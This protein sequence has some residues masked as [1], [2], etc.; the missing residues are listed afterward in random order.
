MNLIKSSVTNITPQRYLEE[1]I[2][3]HIELCGRTCYTEDTEVLT[4]TGFKL[5]KDLTDTDLVLTYNPE[6]NELVYDN[7][8]LIIKDYSGDIIESTHLNLKFAVTP[9]HRLYQSTQT[10]RDYKF[11]T[12]EEAYS[13]IKGSKQNKFRIPKFFAGAY[14]HND[15]YISELNNTIYIKNGSRPDTPQTINLPINNDFIDL[16]GAF[17][18]E[19][20]TFHG[21][22]YGTGSYCQI[23]Q[24]INSKLYT[25]VINALSNLKIKYSISQ[26]PR[27]PDI[28]WIKFGNKVYVET[29]ECL[30]GRYSKNIHLPVWFR[31]L[32]KQQMERLLYVL[33][34]GDGSHNKTRNE[35]YLS[36][37]KT[38]LNQ[39]Q[40]LHILTGTNATV[41]YDD[42][43]SQKCYTEEN[44]RDSWVISRDQLVKKHYSGKVYCTQTSS[45]I[46]CIRY[47][48][49]TCWCGNCYKS[50]DKITDTSA[51][52]FVNMLKKN[53]HRSVLEHG[54]VYLKLSLDL[55][56]PP[57][58]II[59]LSDII[60]K[61]RVNP[62]SEEYFDEIND[63]YYITTN[64]RVIIEN[65]WEE[66]LQY[67]I[68][69]PNEHQ[70]KRYT[71]RITCSRAIANEVVRHRQLSFSQEST[72][73]CNYSTEKFGK[74]LTYIIPSKFNDIIPIGF[75]YKNGNYRLGL[76]DP[77]T[78][79][80]DIK[81][82]IPQSLNVPAKECYI[83]E[84]YLD[85]LLYAEKDYLEL[86]ELGLKPEEARGVLPLDLKTDL[87]VTGTKS[88]WDDFFEL[89]CAK[90]AHPDIQVIANEIKKQIG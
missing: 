53:K 2:L 75:A 58:H 78:L 39:V 50:E 36:I 69:I 15:E 55:H 90:S 87:I 60:S 71:F 12:A 30:F 45:G 57:K 56:Q 29:F 47:K 41:S 65:G 42:I 48:N 61:Y 68:D 86:S 32:S 19:G 51:E 82:T 17:V 5:F 76:E 27:K 13:G 33:Y 34:L 38:L 31:L 84:R 72:R 23:T 54:T 52:K 46:I 74:F 59:E 16:M 77:Y 26:D 14:L 20:Y 62:Y 40:E 85:T 21:E 81:T 66:D 89:R 63:I 67:M 44:L 9:E 4:D 28:K 6:T 10:S 24:N 64:Y 1:D 73:Y 7:N 70:E 8:N 18:S 49:K 80:N 11:I 35:K 37:S 79:T 43:V 83:I 3:K 25:I 88:Q 22:K